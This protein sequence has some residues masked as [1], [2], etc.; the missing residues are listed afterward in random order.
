[1]WKG[2]TF[3][4]VTCAL[5]AASVCPRDARAGNRPDHFSLFLPGRICEKA[6]IRRTLSQV[7]VNLSSEPK[8]KLG[9]LTSGPSN[10]AILVESGNLIR[11]LSNASNPDGLL[12]YAGLDGEV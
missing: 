11:L 8:L 4:G 1:M 9:L 6:P 10:E 2:G 12:S 7:E 5:F 3:I